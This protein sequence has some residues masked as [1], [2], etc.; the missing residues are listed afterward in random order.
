MSDQPPAPSDDAQLGRWLM[1][2]PFL[3]FVAL[4]AAGA[5]G[6]IALL[7][8]RPG[9]MAGFDLAVVG[10]V[11]TT[12]PLLRRRAT[13]IRAAAP[14]HEAHRPRLFVILATVAVEL[15]G[16]QKPNAG[17]IALVVATL[18]LAWLFTT[19][20]YAMHYAHL[21]YLEGPDG[22]RGGLTFPERPEPDYWDF[23]YFSATMG[24][25]FQTSDVAITSPE[26]RRVA[27]VHA[28]AAFVFNLGVLAFS[29]NVLGAN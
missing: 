4:A 19:V 15:A 11:G 25:T 5:A 22:D 28:V 23:L 14:R 18:A 26:V 9:I 7:G 1:P 6:G 3:L 29:V 16:R 8:T 17:A 27:L 2:T 24:M 21:F 13:A 12:V 10:F 20:V